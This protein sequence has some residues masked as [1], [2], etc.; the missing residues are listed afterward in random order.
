MI[1]FSDCGD[2]DL[3]SCVAIDNN[4]GANFGKI[5]MAGS[6]GPYGGNYDFAIARYHLTCCL[7]A[8]IATGVVVSGIFNHG[9]NLSW[10]SAAC[11][12]DVRIAID[13]VPTGPGWPHYYSAG[14]GTNTFSIS[15]LSSS[16]T[17]TVRVETKTQLCSSISPWT[18]TAN[19]TARMDGD[20][21][22]FNNSLFNILIYPNPSAGNFNISFENEEVQDVNYTVT[23]ILGQVVYSSMINE[24]EGTINRTIELNDV[25]DGIYSIT[26]KTANGIVTKQVMIAR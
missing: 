24:T 5:V 22:S 17:Y 3:G 14:C 16:Y 21:I 2:D 23:N 20:N 7:A 4:A 13:K 25:A 8:N 18:P 10:T 11:C 26:V 19:Y 12:S 9:F 6:S 1:A 15:T